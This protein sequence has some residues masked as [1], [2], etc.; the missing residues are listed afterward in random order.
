MATKSKHVANIR[1]GTW[2]E[3]DKADRLRAIADREDRSIASVIR[4]A[5]ERELE[6]DAA[7]SEAAA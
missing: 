7:A 1:I 2:L 3:V 5:V 6:L 4:R